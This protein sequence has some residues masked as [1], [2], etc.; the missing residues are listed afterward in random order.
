MRFQWT[1]IHM[2]S[3]TA[4]NGSPISTIRLSFSIL[5][6]FKHVLLFS[7]VRVSNEGNKSK[8]SL[9]SSRKSRLRPISHNHDNHNCFR[10]TLSKLA[11]CLPVCRR[12]IM[13]TIREEASWESWKSLPSRTHGAHRS[14]AFET[15]QLTSFEH[16]RNLWMFNDRDVRFG[17]SV[18]E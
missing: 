1:L 2:K 14:E 16:H 13:I 7:P 5:I 18:R 9:D 4:L 17:F 6:H 8:I 10:C 15:A 12:I 3:S 11:S